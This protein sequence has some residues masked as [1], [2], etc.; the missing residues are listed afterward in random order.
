MKFYYKSSEAV[1]RNDLMDEGYT[2]DDIHLY[3]E[4]EAIKNSYDNDL[5]SDWSP[6]CRY[7][8]R[9][10]DS[11]DFSNVHEAAEA[12]YEFEAICRYERINDL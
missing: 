4:T 10:V 11:S 8:D 9:F 12:F 3:R 5:N 6:V 2:P 1:R 7:D